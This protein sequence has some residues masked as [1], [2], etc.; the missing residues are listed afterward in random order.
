MTSERGIVV[1]LPGAPDVVLRRA[2]FDFNG[3]LAVDGA[4]LPGI[5]E[6][7]ERL[8]ARLEIH[9]LT[10]D[11]W[12]TASAAL[13]GLPLDLAVVH[14]GRQKADLVAAMGAAETIAVGN[15]RNDVE[16]FERAALAIAVLGPEGLSRAALDA[17]SLVVGAPADAIDLLLEPRRLASTLKR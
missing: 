2:V 5:A 13:V 1:S 6:R 8:A 12:G 14:A 4:L 15:G 17:A 16:M 9:V 11:T 10:S 7:L 3:T